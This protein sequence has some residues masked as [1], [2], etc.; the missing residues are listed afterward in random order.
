VEP[1]LSL[2]PVPGGIEVSVRY[3]TRAN[4]RHNLRA[5]IYQEIVNILGKKPIAPPTA[6]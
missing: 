6:A 2:K 5:Q 3:I 1:A 4:E